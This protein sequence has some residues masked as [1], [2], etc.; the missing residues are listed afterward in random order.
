MAELFVTAADAGLQLKGDG[1]SEL[2]LSANHDGKGPLLRG[3]HPEHELI[4]NRDGIRVSQSS[5]G[6]TT[7]AVLSASKGAAK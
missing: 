7:E 6:K 2:L 1:P 3:R 5:G 4:A